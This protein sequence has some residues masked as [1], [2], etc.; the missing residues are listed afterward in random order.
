MKITELDKA[1]FWIKVTQTNYCWEW[2]SSLDECGYGR[3]SLDGEVLAHR[4]AYQLIHGKISKKILVC[5]SC[6]NP[7]C[8]NPSHLFIGNQFDNMFDKQLKSNHR[9]QGRSSR[10]HGVSWRNDSKRWRSWIKIQGKLVSLGN[11]KCEI[12][13]AK[14]YDKECYKQFKRKE[15]LNFPL[16]EPPEKE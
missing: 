10:Y 1:R 5:H 4:I 7:K 2:S 8:V 15:M 12:E 16:P 6:D 3:F 9:R 11:F 14:A 13:A